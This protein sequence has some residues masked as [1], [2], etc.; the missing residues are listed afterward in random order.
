[1]EM[2]LPS[3]VVVDS[4]DS[5]RT[6]TESSIVK[7]WKGCRKG[8]AVVLAHSIATEMESSIVKR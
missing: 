5:T 7:R 8:Y 4:D 6:V 3:V 1:M 2:D